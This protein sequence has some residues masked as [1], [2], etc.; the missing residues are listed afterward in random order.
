[1]RAEIHLR[2]VR[3][4]AIL[5]KLLERKIQKLDKMLHHFQDGLKNLKIV[6]EQE[7]RKRMYS[8]Q[9]VLGLPTG[10]IKAEKLGYSS[11]EAVNKA[12]K[13]ILKEVTELKDRLNRTDDYK[14][15]SRKELMP[16]IQYYVES[17]VSDIDTDIWETDLEKSR[18][19]EKI[20][21]KLS[22]YVFYTTDLIASY[23]DEMQMHLMD[24]IYPEEIINT[25]IL[26]L[27]GGERRISEE[28]IENEL[29]KKIHEIIRAKVEE[30]G[31]MDRNIPL[32][33]RYR[34]D[35]EDEPMDYYQ[36]DMYWHVE[37]VFEDPN[38][39]LP[40][41][42]LENQETRIKLEELM[43]K[44]PPKDRQ[45]FYLHFIEGYDID[46]LRA[47]FLTDRETL[48]RE[49]NDLITELKDIIK[50]RDFLDR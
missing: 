21:P 13:A 20:T 5:K 9:L 2:K 27:L 25:A 19:L 11:I 44:I 18:I 4:S 47:I 32:E 8:A 3:G 1:M 39:V 38:E 36:P 31:T 28:H 48:E 49:I 40:E 22:N 15:K 12:F 42:L 37:D 33:A 46:D 23:E 7:G 14:R 29:Y 35:N 10:T 6:L 34:E 45:L 26:D 41:E 50:T 17:S 43:N 30:I 16:I 24:K